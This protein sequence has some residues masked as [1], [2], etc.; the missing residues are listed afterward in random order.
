MNLTEED[1]RAKENSWSKAGVFICFTLSA[2]LLLN[3]LV[4]P[5]TLTTGSQK[6]SLQSDTVP[7]DP[8]DR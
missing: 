6:P 3:S 7:A 8:H 1:C 4:H 2:A 5:K